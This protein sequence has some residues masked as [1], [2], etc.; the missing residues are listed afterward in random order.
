MKKPHFLSLRWR[1]VLPLC[2]L[3]LVIVTTGAYLMARQDANVTDMSAVNILDQSRR[4]I[5]QQASVLYENQYRAAQGVVTITSLPQALRDADADS[6]RTALMVRA[7]RANLDDLLLVNA[8]GQ[9]V[10]GL[11]RVVD[12][13]RYDTLTVANL[14]TN[15]LFKTVRSQDVAAEFTQ[16][17]GERQLYTAL[18][19]R[20]GDSF[21]G[22]KEI[23]SARH[24]S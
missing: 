23:V 22:T 24:A 14:S 5:D 8:R 15:S 17:D 4:S 13:T 21:L 19:V 11:R 2:A 9:V 20:R 16:I 7:R 18:P 3:I 1:L 6:L 10:L 12:S